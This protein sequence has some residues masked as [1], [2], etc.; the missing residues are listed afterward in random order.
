[1][2]PLHIAAT[3]LALSLL[4][5]PCVA[6]PP[7]V[8]VGHV[9]Q[10]CT[11]D[12]WKALLE[13]CSNLPLTRPTMYHPDLQ[14]P[15][16]RGFESTSV[17]EA[18]DD[19]RG[20]GYYIFGEEHGTGHAPYLAFSTKKGIAELDAWEI[21]IGRGLSGSVGWTSYDVWQNQTDA[22]GHW[23]PR[24]RT[25]VFSQLNDCS[26]FQVEWNEQLG[27]YLMFYHCSTNA[28]VRVSRQA[29]G[30]WSEATVLIG[31][32]EM[33]EAKLLANLD[34]AGPLQAGSRTATIYWQEGLG[35]YSAALQQVGEQ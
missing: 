18:H 15:P 9:E 4:T 5:G 2:N 8:L 14:S 22:E 30:P 26:G 28:V 34:A 25:R 23:K 35:I 27:R 29:W 17:I 1:M 13:V 20:A 7:V 19:E 21:F 6:Q 32:S 12:V 3:L 16:P 24:D 10:V 31:Q 11:A 33:G